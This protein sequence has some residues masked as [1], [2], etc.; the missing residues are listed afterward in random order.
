MASD[1]NDTYINALVPTGY[2]IKHVDRDDGRRGGGVALIYKQSLHIKQT[3]H[4]A[5]TQFEYML[6]ALTIKNICIIIGVKCQNA[7]I[8]PKD[9][10]ISPISYST[11][12]KPRCPLL[13]LMKN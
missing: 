7:K 5:Y 4:Q 10:L 3:V 1:D 11:H 13:A 12:N 9:Y 6:C 8:T 2:S